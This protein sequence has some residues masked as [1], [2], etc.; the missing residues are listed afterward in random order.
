MSTKEDVQKRFPGKFQLAIPH[1]SLALY[2]ILEKNWDKIP[3][4]EVISAKVLKRLIQEVSS[5]EIPPDY[6]L[7]Y[8]PM[9]GWGVFV[10]PGKTV[11]AHKIVGIYTGNL[12]LVNPRKPKCAPK[13]EL[14]DS[15]NFLIETDLIYLTDEEYAD[16]SNE[17]SARVDQ[18]YKLSKGLEFIIDASTSGNFTRFVNHSSNPNI[19]ACARIAKFDDGWQVI[20]VFIAKKTIF[21]NEPLSIDYGP[22]YWKSKGITPAEILST[23]FL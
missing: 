18:G 6:L 23:E 16:L 10:A 15:Y 4:Y 11:R 5:N 12:L 9:I 7:K 22:G 1:C 3:A 14:D 13:L 21:E 17:G 8:H 2:Q 20:I 19:E